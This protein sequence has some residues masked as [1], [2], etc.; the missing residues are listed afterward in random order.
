M[1]RILLTIEYNG[2]KYAGWQR[3]ENALAVQQVVEDALG[4]LLQQKVVL[5]ASGRTDAGVHAAA[6]PAHFDYDGDF[7]IDR[8]PVASQTVLPED[9]AILKAETVDG[10]FHAQY[11]AKKKTYV[12]KMY[13]SRENHPLLND[14]HAWISYTEDRF[15]FEKARR[16][17]EKLVGTHDFAGFSN[18]GSNVRSTVRTIYAAELEKDGMFVT[19]KVTGSGFLYNMVRIIAGTVVYVGLGKRN[20]EDIE[21]ILATQDR[22]LAGKTFPAQGLCLFSV[23]Y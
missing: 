7:P 15:D 18:K 10:D 21:K 4:V 22:T 14:A 23:E 8:I 13:L 9:I 3:Q 2:K 6:Q 19:L 20:V 11:A 16:A 1:T 5:F 17:C 12:Y